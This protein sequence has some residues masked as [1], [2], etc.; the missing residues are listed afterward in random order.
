MNSKNLFIVNICVNQKRKD[1]DK[2]KDAQHFN[3]RYN[4]FVTVCFVHLMILAICIILEWC[5]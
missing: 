3:V 4:I 5:C 1:H 2:R